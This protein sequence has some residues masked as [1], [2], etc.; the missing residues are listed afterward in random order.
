MAA[1]LVAAQSGDLL[2]I[3]SAAT[4]GSG[5]VVSPPMSFRNHLFLIKGN[6]TIGAGAIQLEAADD[7]DY[8]GVWA[9][10]TTPITVVTSAIVLFQYVGI[11]P[12]IRARVSTTVTTTTAT[13]KYL[14]GKNF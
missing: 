7:P 12:F 11:L 1:T 5:T 9:A 6:G 13:V 14:G 4:T 10:I 3:L 8:T 2:T